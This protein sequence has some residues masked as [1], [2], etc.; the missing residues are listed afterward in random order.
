MFL[1]DDIVASALAS[2]VISVV[3]TLVFRGFQW[4][5]EKWGAVRA[6]QSLTDAP[7]TETDL[8]MS[9]KT[10]EAIIQVFGENAYERVVDA[11]YEEKVEYAQQLVRKLTELYGLELNEC[12]LYV[13]SNLGNC[14]GFIPKERRISLNIAALYSENADQVYEFLDTVVHELRHA[15]QFQAALS[16]EFAARWNVSEETRERWKT[17]FLNYAKPDQDMRA[18]ILQPV[19]SDARTFAHHGTKGIRNN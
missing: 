8:E 12:Q 4:L 2:A 1:I 5:R 19:E 10:R 9:E 15:V 3:A 7:M 18:Y 13:D 14:G 16:E 17:N 11:S 6:P